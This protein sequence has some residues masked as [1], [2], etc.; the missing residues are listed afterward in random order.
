MK[1]YMSAVNHVSKCL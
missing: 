1:V